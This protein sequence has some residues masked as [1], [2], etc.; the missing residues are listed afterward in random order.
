MEAGSKT[1]GILTGASGT[2]VTRLSHRNGAMRCAYC[3]L[4]AIGWF[5]NPD[6]LRSSGRGRF[7]PGNRIDFLGFR[8][9]RVLSPARTLYLLDL[10]NFTTLARRP[11]RAAA[12]IRSA[13][14]GSLY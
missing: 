12:G 13:E 6:V 5:F 1:G 14:G 2:S 3:A 4:R 8:V 9:A 10:Y 7:D 11:I